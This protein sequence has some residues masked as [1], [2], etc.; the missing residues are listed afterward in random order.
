[1]PV[2]TPSE[3]STPQPRP[4]LWRLAALAAGALVAATVLSP[5]IFRI[6]RAAAASVHAGRA[7]LIDDVIEAPFCDVFTRTAVV[8]L[9][10]AVVAGWRW[11]RVRIE[12][13][14]MFRLKRAPLR[15]AVWLVL[16]VLSICLLF[17][18][19]VHAGLWLWRGRAAGDIA[20]RVLVSFFNAVPVGVIEELV[21][22]GIILGYLLQCLSKHRALLLS[23]VIF[24]VPHLFSIEHFLRPIK[25]VAVDG[26]CW[27][28]GWTQ[29]GLYLSLLRDPLA[30]A[31]GLIGLFF[32]G[33]LLAELAVRTKS[34]WASIGMHTGWVFAIKA[35]GQ[36]WRW[37]KAPAANAGPAWFYGEKYIATGV[38]GWILLAVL[39]CL[40]N[41]MLAYAVFR[42]LSALVSS[43]PRAAVV[44]LGRLLG[45]AGYYV[46]VRH[47]PVA[48]ANIALAFPERTEAERREIARR[49][50]ETLGVTCLEVLTFRTIADDFLSIAKPEGLE[51]IAA[52]HAQGRGIV[53]FTGHYASWELLAVGCGVL[54]YPFTA[55]ARPFQNEW[56]YAHIQKVRR[57]AG[58]EILDKKGISSDVLACLR[59][60]GMVGFVG[61]QYAGSG[62]LFV[63]FFGVPAST[64]PAMATF[65]RK[66]GA[67]LIPAFDHLMPDGTHHPVIHPPVT[68]RRTDDA[69]ADVRAMTQDLMAVLEREI[70]EQPWQW[71]WAHRKWRRR[72][73]SE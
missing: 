48:L 27:H 70:R 66:T 2:A 72:K 38:L 60:N 62:G 16:G 46:D 61:D 40:V 57:S 13:R 24:A 5:F 17:A 59:A 34:L 31:P 32:A 21:F 10:L 14:R 44:R 55:V 68:L 67:A 64:S 41:G 29:L 20:R 3:T 7:A 71:L 37:N 45:R 47:R 25:D 9:V 19:Q 30:L 11:L 6:I 53:F 50:F 39:V 28:A 51:H 22:R 8:C 65:A 54:H 12:W 4:A 42:V 26:T 35:L 33:W 58:I 36:A 63:D 73:G 49:S 23:A 43:L 56:I 15:A 1:M 52:A 69:A 18:A